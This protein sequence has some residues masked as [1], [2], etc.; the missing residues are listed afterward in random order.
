MIVWV[1]TL[2]KQ[3]EFIMTDRIKGFLVTLDKDIREDDVQC[4]IDA[5]KMIKHVHSVKSYV[6]G[7]E[8]YMAYSKAESDIGRKI[9]EFVRKE[10]FHIEEKK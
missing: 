9:M 5:I 1:Y 7:M 6:T 10:L 2:L 3:M 4:I 8:D